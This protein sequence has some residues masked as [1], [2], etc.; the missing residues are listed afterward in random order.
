VTEPD[1][2]YAR[3]AS[4][5]TGRILAV[6]E[7]LTSARTSVAAVSFGPA[8]TWSGAAADGFAT[9]VS[10]TR[11]A[12]TG[13]SS[14]LA[15]G[16]AVVRAA[17][18][19]YRT[20]RGGA[21]RT[22]AA[23][24]A[25]AMSADQAGAVLTGLRDA[26]E[27][28]LRAYAGALREMTPTTA[29]TAP[30]AAPVPPPGTTPTAVAAWWAALSTEERT[31]LLASSYD[32]LGRLRGLPATVLDEA[33]RLRLTADRTRYAA[34]VADLD[35]RI[36]ARAAEL[37]LDPTD[38]GALREDGA[39]A[40]L[41]DDRLAAARRSDNAEAAAARVAEASSPDGVYV[42]SYDA[43]GP[44][45][46]GSLVVAYGDPDRATNVAVVVPGTGTTLESFGPNGSAGALRTAMDAV[47]PGNAVIAWL[48]YDAPEWDLTVT[49]PD[50]ARAGA[51][52][53][54]SDVEGYRA[55]AAGPQHIS[56][57]GHSYGSAT[58][59]YAAMAGLDAQDVAFLGSPGV[60]A[61]SVDQLSADH[62]WAG[63]SEH[64]PIVQAT[65]GSWFTADGSSIGPYD[66]EFGATQF[67]VPATTDLTG[68]HSVYFQDRSLEN[69]AN[70]AT[71]NY[72]AVTPDA[73]DNDMADLATGLTDAGREA[74]TGDWD[75][76]WSELTETGS[77][78]LNDAGDAALGGAGN[79][80]ETGK[81][82][83]DNTIGRLF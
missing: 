66:E 14:R 54:V 32:A 18:S 82:F 15:D 23:F 29:A 73:P 8:P 6:L 47:S 53:L 41:L 58:V 43:T 55:S 37:G 28:T 64:D 60:G 42:L 83:Y 45:K 51:E 77:E 79:L 69:L 80:V 74:L 36:A 78:L 7:P 46:D 33:N 19:A 56:V 68:A 34:A 44:G 65:S 2:L 38:E 25:G 16:M 67:D 35:A 48:G 81:S 59:G 5:D 63:H 11:A 50:N 72:D 21:D 75:S 61:S 27:E 52:L 20:M 22:M 76:A 57:F 31:R 26:Y 4:G 9:R 3:L 17:A 62:V 49:S 13:V 39:L 24:R 30:G 10:S 40:D 1:E 12:V 71:G 70:I